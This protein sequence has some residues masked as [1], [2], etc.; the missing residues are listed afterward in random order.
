MKKFVYIVMIALALFAVS[1]KKKSPTAPSPENT[2]LPTATITITASPADTATITI[3]ATPT[4][5]ATATMTVTCTITPLETVGATIPGADFAFSSAAELADWS[6]PDYPFPVAYETAEYFDAPGS[7]ST[8]TQDYSMAW[9][10]WFTTVERNLTNNTI[11]FYLKCPQEMAGYSV[12]IEINEVH[13]TINV[14]YINGLGGWQHFVYV[15]E[16]PILLSSLF[17]GVTTPQPSAFPASKVYLDSVDF[18]Y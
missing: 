7:M 11:S 8:S 16:G 17:I 10:Y 2:P 1:C 13:D 3:T 5:T 6:L 18:D 14:G 12:D 15:N 4:S 9:F